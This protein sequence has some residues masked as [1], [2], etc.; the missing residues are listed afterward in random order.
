MFFQKILIGFAAGIS[1]FLLGLSAY[2]ILIL[3]A[4]ISS[5]A[6]LPTDRISING[7]SLSGHSD[8]LLNK[9]LVVDALLFRNYEGIAVYPKE[10]MDCGKSD[11]PHGYLSSDFEPGIY[12][13]LDM[14]GYV[15]ANSDLE[16]LFSTSKKE[17]EIEVQIEGILLR[18]PS[19]DFPLRYKLVPTS[20]KLRSPWR[21]FTPKGA[22]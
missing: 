20:I 22:A 15:S 1:T 6:E 2:G 17:S 13:V 3:F 5:V 14:S 4:P 19:K 21:Q 16:Y 7:C 12:T 9:P 18:C 10:G 11:P 8:Q